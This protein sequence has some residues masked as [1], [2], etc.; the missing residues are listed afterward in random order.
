[1]PLTGNMIFMCD[2]STWYIKMHDLR[3]K[4]NSVNCNMLH[5]QNPDDLQRARD[6]RHLSTA[7]RR[8]IGMSRM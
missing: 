7:L 5:S 4:C 1:M 8:S 2:G 6:R 3:S